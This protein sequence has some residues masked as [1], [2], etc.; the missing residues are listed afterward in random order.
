M[1]PRNRINGRGSGVVLIALTG[2]LIIVG[3][4]NQPTPICQA[5]KAGSKSE[6]QCFLSKRGQSM[7]SMIFKMINGQIH[8]D[9][10]RGFEKGMEEMVT[11]IN[12]SHQCPIWPVRRAGGQALQALQ[13]NLI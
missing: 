8:R 9:L 6:Y 7:K 5:G 1:K 4:F 3:E 12:R 10:L 11:D 13:L 2:N